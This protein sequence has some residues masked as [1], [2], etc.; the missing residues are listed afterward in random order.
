MIPK[1]NGALSA[2]QGGVEQLHIIDGRKPHALL[3]HIKGIESQGT[4]IYHY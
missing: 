2:I 1:V 3:L 4:I